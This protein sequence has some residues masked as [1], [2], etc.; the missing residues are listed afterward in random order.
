VSNEIVIGGDSTDIPP[1]TYPGT[2]TGLDIKHS[3]KF[4]NDF[5]VWTFTLDTGSVVEGSSSMSTNSKSKGGRWIAGMLGRVPAKGESVSLLGVRC[6]VQVIVGEDG[7]PK[8]EAVIAEPSQ[9]AQ[10]ARSAPSTPTVAPQ[11]DGLDF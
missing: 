6:L 5:R 1:G 9:P 3:D 8:V 2:L 7:W 4:D 10:K 11:T